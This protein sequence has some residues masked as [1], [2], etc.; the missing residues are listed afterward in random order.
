MLSDG[1]GL[2][3]WPGSFFSMAAEIAYAER[4]EHTRVHVT[5]TRH[6]ARK[7]EK[8]SDAQVAF[9]V[10]DGED[11]TIAVILMCFHA[12]FLVVSPSSK[13]SQA[14]AL[15]KKRTPLKESLY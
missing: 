11:D 8:M 13:G 15:T 1:F 9:Y 12:I 10:L 5:A 6:L 2:F 4:V 14:Y 7:V 3:K